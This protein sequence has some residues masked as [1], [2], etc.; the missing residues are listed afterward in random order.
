MQPVAT[1]PAHTKV[2]FIGTGIMGEPMAGHVLAAGYRLLVHNR[3]RGKAA[4][5]VERGATWCDSVEKLAAES[6]IVLT[7]VGYPRDVEEVYLGAGGVVQHA[8]PGTR[9]VDLT[10]SDPE[11]AVRIE[12]DG[13]ARGL[14]CLDAPVTGGETGAKKAELSIMVGGHPEDFA[15]LEPL[16]ACI[17]RAVLQGPP[18]AGQ[19]A[20]LANQI[21]IAGTMLGVCESLAY[22]ER[23][24]LDPERVLASISRG[25][26]GSVLLSTMGPRILARDDAPGFYVKHFIKD[27]DLALSHARTFEL[28]ARGLALARAL[29]D[30]LARRGHADAGT[31]ALF[32]LYER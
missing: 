12:R 19:H 32:R 11:L 18:G 1:S 15:A 7:I 21:A 6:D 4:R 3:S 30:E 27:M 5:L 29:Y 24:G 8:R 23:A 13:R 25:A 14:C 31:Q 17:G 9:L 22:A 20:K 2:G 10:T 16:F 28:D 26:A